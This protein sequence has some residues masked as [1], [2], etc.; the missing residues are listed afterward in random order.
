LESR[1]C[2]SPR[3][4]SGTS[5]VGNVVTGTCL[6]V[7]G[8][9]VVLGRRLGKLYFLP[10]P[11]ELSVNATWKSSV[12]ETLCF[13]R[14]WYFSIYCWWYCKFSSVLTT[15]FQWRYSTL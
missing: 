5:V 14:H 12:T 13:Q 2:I 15:Y 1:S 6:V 9:D 3:V 11:P 8:S 7:N 4:S 10:R